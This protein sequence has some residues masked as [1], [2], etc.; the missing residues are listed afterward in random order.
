MQN[1]NELIYNIENKD[2]KLDFYWIPGHTDN[3]WNDEVDRLAKEAAASWSNPSLS[4]P[5]SRSH[6]LD[7]IHWNPAIS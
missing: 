2:I 3:K 4:P 5:I 6:S 7:S 1:I